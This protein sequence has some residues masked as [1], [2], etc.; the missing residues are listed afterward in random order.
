MKIMPIFIDF[1]NKNYA[2]G[3]YQG[4]FPQDSG[5]ELVVRNIGNNLQVLDWISNRDEI[6]IRG[7]DPNNMYILRLNLCWKL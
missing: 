4:L 7:K 6:S 3:W 1:I 5:N 2:F